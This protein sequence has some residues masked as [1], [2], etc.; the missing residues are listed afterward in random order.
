MLNI[1]NNL[2]FLGVFVFVFIFGLVIFF[3][4]N[5]FFLKIVYP[6]KYEEL[7][8]EVS[9][10]YNMEPEL[11][12]AVM[13]VESG[14]DENAKSSAG[15]VGLMQLMPSTFEWLKM[16][17]EKDF[18]SCHNL[19]DPSVNIRAGV[20][21]LGILRKKYGSEILVLCAYNAGMNAVD[22]WIE[23]GKTLDSYEKISDIP[24]KETRDYV[25][26]VLKCKEMYKMLYF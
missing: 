17:K 16:G 19:M 1:K 14:F 11:V 20:H 24:Y 18:S 7:V 4:G 3:V 5:R 23:K 15:A 10:D 9:N 6:I 26:K 21:F 2:G 12:Y 8:K 13:K 22:K 25:R